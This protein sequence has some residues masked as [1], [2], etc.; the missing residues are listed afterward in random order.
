[1]I[2]P[3]GIAILLIAGSL[4]AA[5]PA[6]DPGTASR[7]AQ[8][9]E[10]ISRNPGQPDGHI[11]LALALVKAARATDHADYL[12]QA[13]Q[14]AADA[15]HIAPGSFEAQKSE[16][17]IRLAEHRYSE[18]L[19]QAKS[20]N[21]QVPDDNQMYGYIADAEMALGDY[22]AAEKAT[23]WM[24]DQRPVNAPGLQRG[25]LLRED[26]G[27]SEPALEWW[28]SALRITSS[29]DA[30]ERA[31]ILVNMSRVRLR[32]GKPAD[33]EKDARQALQLVPDYPWAADAL[34]AS[35][36]EQNQPAQAAVILAHRVSN[37]PD[38]AAE[39]HLAVALEASGKKSEA[40]AAFQQ[41]ET[42]ASARAGKPDGATCELIEYYVTHDRVAAGVKLASEEIERRSDIATLA[43]YAAA[44]TAAGRY[45]EARVQMGRALAPGIRDAKLF[46]RAGMIAAKLKDKAAAA[47]YL[48]KTIEINASSPEADQAIKL[49]ANL[50]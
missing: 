48:K 5:E 10:Q 35:L 47:S 32:L 14:A 30:E 16:V 3:Y 18:A 44:L 28:N 8:A 27:Y 40:D 29:A 49:L 20:L 7:I 38:L 11:A 25:A 37:A 24:I 21:K 2:K 39:F 23:Q 46:Y 26:F 6:L 13:E 31:W 50:S 43:A 19:S 34:A 12:Q 42:Q 15:L 4:A 9:K 22:A 36:A 17:A 41:F 33:A 45:D 1:M